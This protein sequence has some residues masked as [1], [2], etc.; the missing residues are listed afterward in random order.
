MLLTSFR[1]HRIGTALLVLLL[2]VA[3]F[4]LVT[5]V[6]M[7]QFRYGGQPDCQIRDARMTESRAVIVWECPVAVQSPLPVVDVD[8]RWEAVP[9]DPLL[10][11]RFVERPPFAFRPPPVS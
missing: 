7:D 11:P 3:V 8:W 1:N 4:F 6:R 9:I 2:G 10:T 5:Q